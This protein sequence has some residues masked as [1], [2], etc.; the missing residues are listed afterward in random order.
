MALKVDFTFD[1]KTYR[2]YMNGFLSVM[3]CHHYLCLTS[4]LAMDH[5]DLGGTIIL[6]EVAEDTIRPLFDDYF[7]KNGVDSFKDRILIGIEYYSVMGLGKMKVSA[8]ETGGQVQL[9]RSHVDQGWLKKWGK[10]QEHVNFFTRGYIA[11]MFAAA[12]D[13]PARSVEVIETES[14]VTGSEAGVMAVKIG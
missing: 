9:L 8:N 5:D 1:K 13:K 2:H 4:K 12:L 6:M 10:N 11:A 3:H 14:I 7:Q